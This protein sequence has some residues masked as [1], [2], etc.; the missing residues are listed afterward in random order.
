MSVSETDI[1]S[2]AANWGYTQNEVEHI[3]PYFEE[4]GYV[5]TKRSLGRYWVAKV[6]LTARG[7]D[8]VE[9]EIKR[10]VTETEM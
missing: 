6:R 3:I 1:Y 8:Y 10:K 5:E 2:A 4:K 7:V 9:S